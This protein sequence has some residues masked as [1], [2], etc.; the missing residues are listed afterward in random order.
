ME[1]TIRVK[2]YGIGICEEDKKN[3]FSAYFKTKDKQNKKMNSSS[4]GLGLNIC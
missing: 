2:D 3:L 1:V 4:H